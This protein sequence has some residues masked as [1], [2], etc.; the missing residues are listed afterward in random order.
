M[1]LVA[2]VMAG[3]MAMVGTASQPDVAGSG[4]ETVRLMPDTMAMSV[5]MVATDEQFDKALDSIQQQTADVQKALAGL[6]TPPAKVTVDGPTLGPSAGSSREA[7]LR[8]QMMQALGRS[9]AAAA[10]PDKEKVTLST[11]VTA[12]W[13]LT[14][15]DAV[16]LLKETNAIEQAV[17]GALPKPGEEEKQ[18]TEEQEEEML[19][20]MG[21]MDEDEEPPG[22]PTFIFS[23]K[24]PDDKLQA[25]RKKA[26][27]EA[28]KDA[29]S[30][31][32]AA[33]ASLGGL[34]EVSGYVSQGDRDMGYSSYY[35]SSAMMRMAQQTEE[36]T[37]TA[38][39]PREVSFSVSVEV[40]FA[41]K[42]P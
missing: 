38:M 29:G 15:K 4:T 30:L 37:A 10:E 9:S 14:A 41:L 12:E 19:S 18:M 25:A 21:Q 33:G 8:R 16:G 31:A 2:L 28:V 36:L 35:Y 3:L 23:A 24:L 39:V 42:L 5:S 32:E 1:N 6:K 22:T 20:M 13:K 7:S 27:Q 34:A 11:A 26:F 40:T 17:R